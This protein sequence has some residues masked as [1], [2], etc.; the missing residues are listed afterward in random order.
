M[1]ALIDLSASLRW[2]APLAPVPWP[3]LPVGDRPWLEYALEACAGLKITEV[4][5]LLDEGAFEI[6]SWCGNGERWGLAIDYGFLRQETTLTAWLRRNPARWNDG[7][8]VL[9]GPVFLRKTGACAMEL[10]AAGS[11]WQAVDDDAGT[12]ALLSRD[13]DALQR[14]MA[15]DKLPPDSWAMP[16]CAPVALTSLR[17]YFA[18]NMELVDGAIERYLTPGYYAKDG[19]YLGYNVQVPPATELHA[20][21]IVGNDCRFAPLCNIGPRV[22]I[23]N[24]VLVDTGSQLRNCVVLNGT[25]IGR[26][27]ELDGRI[28]NGARLIDPEDGTVLDIADPWLLAAVHHDQNPGRWLRHGLAIA[29]AALM[30][31]VQVVPWLVLYAALRLSGQGCYRRRQV[32][33]RTAGTASGWQFEAHPPSGLLPRLFRAFSFDRF[34]ALLAVITGQLRLCGQERLWVPEDN[35]LRDELPLYSPG[36]FSQADTSPAD[37][38]APATARRAA[39]LYTIHHDSLAENVRLFWRALV[40]RFVDAWALDD[41]R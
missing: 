41:R 6:E 35:L 8:F 23:G 38:L 33:R 3:L 20:P 19:A 26:Q 36:V 22:A 13:H 30:V 10:P 32:Y 27:L 9:R 39:A 29:V 12:L 24:N 31:M 7:L 11:A 14:W 15:D 25:Y 18:L 34:P 37:V 5:L 21:L 17:D 16:C 28:I 1:K 40:I 2:A 4:R